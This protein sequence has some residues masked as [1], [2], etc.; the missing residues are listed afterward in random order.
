MVV[1]I[2]F[3]VF[4]F[5]V[6]ILH[7]VRKPIARPLHVGLAEQLHRRAGHHEC[8]RGAIRLKILLEFDGSLGCFFPAVIHRC[9]LRNAHAP[10]NKGAAKPGNRDTIRDSQFKGC[11][12]SRCTFSVF[13]LGFGAFEFDA[14]A[15]NPRIQSQFS[16]FFSSQRFP[17]LWFSCHFFSPPQASFL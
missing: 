12:E 5:N 16:F 9:L 13:R 10:I 11:P 8:G 7:V 17:I 15:P 3:H 4:L 6:L 1:L 2:G 14:V